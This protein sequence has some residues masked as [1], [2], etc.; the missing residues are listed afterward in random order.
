VIC[1]WLN[2]R[3][4][5]E[6]SRWK[7]LESV[8]SF[9][10]AGSALLGGIISDSQGYSF[11]FAITATVQIVGIWIQAPL[12]GVVGIE[13]QKAAATGEEGEIEDP[14]DLGLERESSP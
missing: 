13:G 1:W 8:A 5:N 11:A 12:I 10:W 9:G 6:R 14:D 7:S 2:F 3:P 4:S